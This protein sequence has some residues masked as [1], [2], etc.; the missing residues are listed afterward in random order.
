MSTATLVNSGTISSDFAEGVSHG[1]L[2]DVTVTNE[3]G[4]V[5]TGATSGIYSGSSGTLTVNN[6]GI[7]R[8]DGAYDGFDAPPDAGVTIGTASSSV[9]NSGTIS[10]AG[11]GITTA[12]LFDEE[13]NQLVLLAVGT[14]VDNRSE[15]HTS[16]LQSLMRIS[17]AV[18][19][20]KK[21]NKRNKLNNISLYLSS[22]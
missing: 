16:E 12:Y 21:K 11:A 19:C 14:T 4:G 22:A 17:Y 18:F 13:I 9:T 3:E 10:G 2:A 1:T 8:G 20:L 15:E 7:I 5:I 6:A